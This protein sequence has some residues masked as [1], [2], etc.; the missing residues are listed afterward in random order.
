MEKCLPTQNL[1]KVVRSQKNNKYLSQK[2]IELFHPTF[3][4]SATDFDTEPKDWL[5]YNRMTLPAFSIQEHF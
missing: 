3:M 4:E 2:T 5:K 1:I